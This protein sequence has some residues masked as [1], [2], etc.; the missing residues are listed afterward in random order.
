MAVSVP[1]RLTLLLLRLPFEF[2]FHLCHL[3]LLAEISCRLVKSLPFHEM[4]F[5]GVTKGCH[6][7]RDTILFL[8]AC[9]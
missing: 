9:D 3:G 4:F 1:G 6:T 8:P 5:V 2:H 7:C